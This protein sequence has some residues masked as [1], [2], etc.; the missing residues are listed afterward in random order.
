MNL[1]DWVTVAILADLPSHEGLGQ[2]S[3]LDIIL[4]I[5]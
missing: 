4:M 5:H 2:L 1:N 3:L